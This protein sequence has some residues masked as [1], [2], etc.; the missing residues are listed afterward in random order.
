[1]GVEAVAA[2]TPLAEPPLPAEVDERQVTHLVSVDEVVPVEELPQ[3][4]T[5]VAPTSPS[6]S[7]PLGGE[8]RDD[9]SF[10]RKTARAAT[11]CSQD[12]KDDDPREDG[13]PVV[14]E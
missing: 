11:T 2:W 9:G 3:P 10:R 4:W 5:G 6:K 12:P 1:R 8:R 13:R 14:E 7:S